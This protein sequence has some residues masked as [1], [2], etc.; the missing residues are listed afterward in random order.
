MKGL[1]VGQLIEQ[2]QR[3]DRDKLVFIDDDL[4]EVTTT[5]LLTLEKAI[6]IEAVG[7]EDI[8]GNVYL[9]PSDE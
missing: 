4:S 7:K 3:F 8:H 2:L 9:M 1:T 6:M 5:G